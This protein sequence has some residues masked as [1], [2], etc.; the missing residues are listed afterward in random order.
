[1]N[2][3]LLD[4]TS[5]GTVDFGD[6]KTW[7]R[8]TGDIHSGLA[9][10]V[11]AHGGP[12]GTHD[13][14]LTMADLSQTG[15]AVIHYDQLGNGKST[16]L[17]DKGADFWTVELFLDEL[18]NLLQ[19][20]GI[21]DA[22]HF[23]GQS[24]GGMLG[25]EHGIR[26]PRGLRS[27][28]ISDSPASMPLWLAAAAKLRADLPADVQGTLLR[29]EAAGTTDSPE[30]LAAMDVFYDRHVCRIVPRPPELART[31]AAIADDPT[32][33]GTMNG[34]SEFHVIG[35]LKDWTVVDR[36]HLIQ[37]PTLLISGHYDE[38][39]PSTIEPFAERIPDVRWHIFADSSHVPHIEERDAYMALVQRFIDDHDR[40]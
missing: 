21:A 38:A 9:P 13:Y 12:G 20:L 34:P 19:Q 24:W 33:Y 39:A 8:I 23:I 10:I 18:E 30:Y 26:Q 11:T 37:A 16:H 14:L 36:V 1:M 4:A 17:R 31:F 28:T 22:Y 40:P 27:L 7:Y 29:H 35:T 5:S 32:V 25:A 3:P 2:K 6:W 15:R